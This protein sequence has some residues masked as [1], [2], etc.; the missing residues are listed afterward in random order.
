M[1]IFKRILRDINFHIVD[2]MWIR[3]EQDDLIKL[4]LLIFGFLFA[5]LFISNPWCKF[6]VIDLHFTHYA[7]CFQFFLKALNV[8][9]VEVVAEFIVLL[10]FA[11]I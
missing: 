1:A 9:L 10:A 2:I 7:L 11:Q 3:I 6:I 8:V 5:V 4:D